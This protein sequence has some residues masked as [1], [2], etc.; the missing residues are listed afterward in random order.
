MI[1]A[2][3][4]IAFLISLVS[5]VIGY[6]KEIY[7]TKISLKLLQFGIFLKVKKLYWLDKCPTSFAAENIQVVLAVSRG[8]IGLQGTLQTTS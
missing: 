2:H 1:K 4:Q 6:Q 8:P 7:M 3:C 5:I